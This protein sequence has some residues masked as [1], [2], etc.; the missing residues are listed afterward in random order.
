MGRMQLE[1]MAFDTGQGHQLAAIAART[2]GRAEA[3]LG[4]NGTGGARGLFGAI[5]HPC[6]P[7]WSNHRSCF[8]ALGYCPICE[9]P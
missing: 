8:P 5:A 9:R 6:F 3:L 4:A 7:R 2:C 1:D